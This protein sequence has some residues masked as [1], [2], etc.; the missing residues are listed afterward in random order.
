MKLHVYKN[1]T[2]LASE[3]ANWIAELIQST[4]QN[5]EFFTLA[6]SGGETPKALFKELASPGFKEKINWKRVEIFWGDERAV[7]PGDNRNNAKA[8]YDL[9]ID[10]I[11]IP[12]EQVHIIRT[13]IEPIFAAKAYEK[14]LHTFFDNTKKSFDLVLLGIG[15]DGHTLSIFPG[16]ALLED[17]EKNWV[18]AVYQQD[19]QMYRI[20]LTPAIV[21]C[22][23]NI[24]FM[25]EGSGK[26]KILKEVIEGAYTPSI[27]PAQ[28]IRPEN[29]ELHW[30]LDTES[31]KELSTD[32]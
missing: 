13:D 12:A 25:V 10:H 29:G 28:L 24:A 2:E 11:D 3:L 14:I 17:T 15:D 8:A 6:L 19:Q 22:S 31:A 21:N 16:S 1:K 30:F 20:T 18:N 27:L 9:F 32:N 5:Q 26:A 4:L 7:P 23:S